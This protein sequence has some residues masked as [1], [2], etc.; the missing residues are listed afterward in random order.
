M[1][2]GYVHS[3]SFYSLNLCLHR[4]LFRS[5]MGMASVIVNEQ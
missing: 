2:I 1:C 4:P 5:G 3:F